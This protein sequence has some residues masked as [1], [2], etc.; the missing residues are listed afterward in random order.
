M[1]IQYLRFKN[2]L[3][4][5]AAGLLGVNFGCSK[6]FPGD[7]Y[8]TP[9]T[10]FRLMG[11]VSD[12]DGN[13]IE[14]IDVQMVGSHAVTDADGSYEVSARTDSYHRVDVAFRDV[15]GEANGS[16]ADTTVTVDYSQ[17]PAHGGD[18]DYYEGE[19]T[20]SLDV[21]LSDKQ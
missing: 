15:D 11:T 20:T 18:G 2:W 13:P 7:M 1:K 4:A 5:A 10:T 19:K 21:T 6:I 16:Y 8:G 12:R 14:G 9:E 3:I 17:V